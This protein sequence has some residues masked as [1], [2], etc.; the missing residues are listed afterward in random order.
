[1]PLGLDNVLTDNVL[2]DALLGRRHWDLSGGPTITYNMPTAVTTTVYS[3]PSD[4]FN[5]LSAQYTFDFSTFAAVT[6]SLRTSINYAIANEIN[7]VTGLNYTAVA[8]NVRADA[9]YGMAALGTNPETGSPLNGTYFS[10]ASIFRGGDAWFSTNPQSAVNFPAANVTP[11]TGAYL[12]ML[13]ELGHSLGLK[14]GHNSEGGPSNPGGLPTVLPTNMDSQ[15]FTIMTYR[16]YVG[17]PITSIAGDTEPNSFAQSL[18]MLDIQALQYLYGAD[19]TTNSGDTVYTFS[20]TTGAMSVN[21]TSLGTPSGNRILRTI[22][23]GGGTDTYDLSNYTTSLVV[24]LAP[25]GWSTFSSAQLAQLGGWTSSTADTFARG[26]VAN[27]LLYNGDTRSLIENVTGGSGNDLLR[28]NDAANLLI[29]NDGYDTLEGGAGNDTLISGNDLD[30]LD[31]GAGSDT[32]S[33]ATHPYFQGVPINFIVKLNAA[34]DGDVDYSIPN[35]TFGDDDQLRSIENAIGGDGIDLFWVTNST[36]RFIDGGLSFGSTQGDGVFYNPGFGLNSTQAVTVDIGIGGSVGAGRDHLVNIE[37]VNGS[38]FADTM[39]VYD[40]VGHKLF[41]SDGNDSLYGG[42][43]ADTLQGWTEDDLLDGGGGADTLNG[44]G[45]N[46]TLIGGDDFDNVFG[47][48]NDDYLDGGGD[49]DYVSGG[50]GNDTIVY[51]V[52]DFFLIGGNGTD[53]LL[54]LNEAAPTTFN[55]AADEFERAIVVTDDPGGN[56]WL[57]ISDYYNTAWQRTNSDT[58][59]DNGNLVQTTYDVSS[60]GTGVNW[61]YISDYRNAAGVLTNQDGKFDNGGSFAKSYDY[62]AGTGTDGISDELRE[63]TYFFA[64]DTDRAANKVLNVEGFY[65]DG[66]KFTQTNDIG[67]GANGDHA[68]TFQTNWYETDGVT[69]DFLEIRWDDGSTQIIPY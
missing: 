41:G 17:A 69:L 36:G 44:G 1:M 46:D 14:H 3:T 64:N 55:L 12:T 40:D 60:G 37:F 67:P 59:A 9:S 54:V 19:F 27:A 23:D 42:G 18:M 11:G 51:D 39:T 34:G 25:G 13:H 49:G 61:Q 2:I 63:F 32:V 56:W 24:D 58:R 31:G 48:D 29:G 43:G 66:R 62:A 4:Y 50:N 33:Y 30:T 5:G 20:P 35:V 22:W 21:G 8:D 10:P 16:R 52:E 7:A 6:P 53:T 15:E 26:N 57:Q 45:G 65:D 47:D 28:G 38:V 68:W